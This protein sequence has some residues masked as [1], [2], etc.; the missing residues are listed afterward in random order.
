MNSASASPPSQAPAAGFTP[1]ERDR[2]V[3]HINGDHADAVLDYARH[4]AG[5]SQGIAARLVD[6]DFEGLDLVVREADG[7]VHVRVPFVPPL[8]DAK[9]AHGAMVRMARE[10]RAARAP[11]PGIDP[12]RRNRA[13]AALAHLRVNVRTLALATVSAEG[14][15]DASVAPFVAERD[16]LLWTYLS[17]LSPHTANLRA[18]GRCAALLIEDESTAA[19]ALA[20]RRLALACTAEFVARDQPEFAPAMA[21]LRVRFGA[22]MEH[23]ESM[24]DFHLV[25]LRPTRARLIAGFGQAYDAAPHDWSDLRPVGDGGHRSTAA[26]SKEASPA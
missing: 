22:V 24:H 18:N 14:E 1:A 19:Q 2:I 7:E 17:D 15:P 16:D 26:K 5:R 11:R 9:A 4:F 6:L 23:L 10:A 20:R 21:A 13:L 3:H 25:R 8:A 12:A